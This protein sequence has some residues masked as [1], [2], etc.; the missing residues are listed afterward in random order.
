MVEIVLLIQNGYVVA[1]ELPPGYVIRVIDYEMAE[2]WLS[3]G[4]DPSEF[5]ELK[6]DENGD[7][8]VSYNA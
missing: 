7:A 2:G 3:Q 8:Y 4:D 1:Q 6:Y 5:E